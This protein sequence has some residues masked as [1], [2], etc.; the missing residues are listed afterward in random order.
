VITYSTVYASSGGTVMQ[1]DLTVT[2]EA[3]S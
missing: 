3:L 2:V 1:Y